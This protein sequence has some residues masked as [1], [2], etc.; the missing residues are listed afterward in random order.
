MRSGEE[1]KVPWQLDRDLLGW[2]NVKEEGAFLESN[3]IG[4]HHKQGTNNT[5]IGV[6][7]RDGAGLDAG[8]PEFWAPGMPSQGVPT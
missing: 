3:V 8:R 1:R 7:N 6:Y 2:V 4:Q 5:R